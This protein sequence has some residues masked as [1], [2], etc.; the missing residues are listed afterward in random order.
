[1]VVS[2]GA[3]IFAALLGSKIGGGEDTK[4]NLSFWQNGFRYYFS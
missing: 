4:T 2:Y 3:H 1:M